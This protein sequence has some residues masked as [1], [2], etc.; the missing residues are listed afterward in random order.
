MN[1]LTKSPQ[2]IEAIV[3]EYLLEKVTYRQLSKKYDLD[4]RVIHSWVMKFEVLR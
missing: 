3:A 1:K 2:E 4:F